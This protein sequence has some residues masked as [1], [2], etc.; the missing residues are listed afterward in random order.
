MVPLAPWPLK[1]ELRRLP[2]PLLCHNSPTVLVKVL[3]RRL[4]AA[5]T[6]FAPLWLHRLRRRHWCGMC[7]EVFAGGRHR[8]CRRSEA[9]FHG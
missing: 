9:S 1:M 2:A 7:A 6:V 8:V 4:W 3:R 5:G